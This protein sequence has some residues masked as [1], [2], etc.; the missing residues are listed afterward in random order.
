[1]SSSF[2]HLLEGIKI[3]LRKGLTK[4]NPKIIETKQQFKR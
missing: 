1:M 4:R 2:Q 3:K